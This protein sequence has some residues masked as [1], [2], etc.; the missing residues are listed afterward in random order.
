MDGAD[1]VFNTLEARQV[2]ENNLI[3]V[4]EEGGIHEP[5]S[6]A[7]RFGKAIRWLFDGREADDEDTSLVTVIPPE[8]AVF[9]PTKA[10][11]VAPTNVSEAFSTQSTF[12]VNDAKG[13]ESLGNLNLLLALIAIFLVV[14]IIILTI[15]LVR[16][17][18]IIRR[19]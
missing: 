18:K 19:E 2:P 16:Q 7:G 5:S 11:E 17:I 4:V 10:P 12:V 6:W 3:L 13:E 9:L 15:L 8:V 14:M 1:A